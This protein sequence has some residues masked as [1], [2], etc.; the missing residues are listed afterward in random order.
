MR[1]KESAYRILS[2]KSWHARSINGPRGSVSTIT[3]WRKSKKSTFSESTRKSYWFLSQCGSSEGTWSL[4][5]RRERRLSTSRK[6]S[7]RMNA[8]LLKQLL[9]PNCWGR[10]SFSVAE[11]SWGESPW[12]CI[13]IMSGARSRC[14]RQAL[15][16]ALK[17]IRRRRSLWHFVNKATYVFTCTDSDVYPTQLS[18]TRFV[19]DI[20]KSICVAK[21]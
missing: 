15:S 17:L 12:F 13:R 3:K 1:L 2:S 8:K 10:S 9:T 6:K 14:G 4:F 21:G 11:M 5:V 7:S 18:L 20:V 19:T 16:N